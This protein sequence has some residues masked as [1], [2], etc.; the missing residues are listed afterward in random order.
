M[1]TRIL[2]VVSL[3]LF[4]PILVFPYTSGQKRQRGNTHPQPT[5][6]PLDFSSLHSEV[7]MNCCEA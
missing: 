4:A 2:I 5:P 6:T 1:R 3:I 7:L